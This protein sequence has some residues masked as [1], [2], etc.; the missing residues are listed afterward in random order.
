MDRSDIR[1]VA[2]F[3]HQPTTAYGCGLMFFRPMGMN[4]YGDMVALYNRSLD[5]LIKH[6]IRGM[7]KD[8]KRV[9]PG[10]SKLLSFGGKFFPDT[11][12]NTMARG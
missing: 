3:K 7:E 11:L 9:V 12:A 1:H 5:T 2:C 8:K 4:K 6:G 10:L